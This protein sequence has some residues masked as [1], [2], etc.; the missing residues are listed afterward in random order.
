MN[1]TTTQAFQVSRYPAAPLKT[2]CIRLMLAGVIISS[3]QTVYADQVCATAPCTVSDGAAH[4]LDST[5]LSASD[6]AAILTV[7]GTGTSLAGTDVTVTNTGMGAAVSVTA[8]SSVTL[9]GSTVNTTGFGD[10]VFVSAAGSSATSVMIEDNSQI[11]TATSTGIAIDDDADA[12]VTLDHSTAQSAN[13]LT[14]FEV[15]GGATATI[16]NGSTVSNTGGLSAVYVNNDSNVSFDA[17]SATANSGETVD[18][19]G[20]AGIRITG[21]SSVT[22]TGTGTGVYTTDAGS[23]A[24]INNSQIDTTS[25]TGRA[26]DVEA[27]S[28]VTLDSSTGSSQNSSATFYVNGSTAAIQNGSN[29]T[30]T[31]SGAGLYATNGSTVTVSDSQISAQS[32]DA[33]DL[34]AGSNTVALSGAT[35]LGA[36]TGGLAIGALAANGMQ[37]TSVDTLSVDGSQIVGDLKI[38]TGALNLVLQNQSLLQGD[39]I[40]AGGTL[41]L[42]LTDNSRFTGAA[43]G[44]TRL[45]LDASSN[46]NMTGNSSVENLNLD[47]AVYF[48]A[49]PGTYRTLTINNLTTTSGSG[50]GLFEMNTD[51]AQ[52]QGDQLAVNGGSGAYQLQIVDHSTRAPSDLNAEL[53]VV[54]TPDNPAP[55]PAAA[56]APAPGGAPTF[57]LAG[58][59]TDVGAY[60]YSLKQE[61]GGWYLYNSAFPFTPVDPIT[62]VNPVIPID[63]RTNSVNATIAA[64]QAVSSIWFNELQP[65]YSRMG[66]L[67]MTPNSD[68]VWVRTYGAKER[69]SPSNSV[70]VDMT[71]YMTEAGFDHRMRGGSGSWYFGA[72]VGAGNVQQTFGDGAGSGTATP[73][74]V[75]TYATWVSDRGWYGDLV[76]KYDSLDQ[77]YNT[78]GSGES[79]SADYHVNGVTA[80]AEAGMRFILPS[81]WFVEPQV[82]LAALYQGGMN[83]TT[84][85]GT[86]VSASGGTAAAARMSVMVGHPVSFKMSSQSVDLE[87]YANL[88]LIRQISASADTTV[89]GTDFSSNVRENRAQ[90]ALGVGLQPLHN[91]QGFLQVAYGKGQH[92]EQPWGF[93]VGIKKVW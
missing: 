66:D 76:L 86:P 40:D 36:G 87:P 79:I 11:G 35:Q 29:V 7:T 92:Y 65:L 90:L 18:V 59:E 80:S 54:K 3:M 71:G 73:T 4:T 43:Q 38:D 58:G 33:L 88:S 82:E 10:A 19:E 85:Y 32:G 24:T 23:S 14:T 22:N 2:I 47:G 77:R 45:N 28:N 1:R 17:S 27:A 81:R 49:N 51:L 46:W 61:S 63:D 72:T 50:S 55:G 53:Q 62:P 15:N 31:G 83:Y 21:R 56:N 12:Q 75:G 39:A 89:A 69:L 41:N 9:A 68:G 42:E 13:G 6:S 48:V 78:T 44:V 70:G 67:R 34:G 74:T 26:I 8:G 57:T 20:G 5:N 52:M 30:N 60:K 93:N 84:T 16:Q 64:Q 25:G 37:T 91:W